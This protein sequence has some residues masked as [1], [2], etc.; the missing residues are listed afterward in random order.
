VGEPPRRSR[1]GLFIAFL[2]PA[3][4]AVV[5]ALGAAGVFVGRR[6]DGQLETPQALAINAAAFGVVAVV[7]LIVGARRRR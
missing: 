2:V 1:I 7:V 5:S 3:A 4:I 6:K